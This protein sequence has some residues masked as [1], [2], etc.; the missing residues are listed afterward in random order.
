MLPPAAGPSV[1]LSVLNN[2]RSPPPW[3]SLRRLPLLPPVPGRP[4]VPAS[5][6]LRMAAAI[7][8]FSLG[9]TQSSQL[10]PPRLPLACSRRDCATVCRE[11]NP[12]LLVETQGCNQSYLS[13]P[14]SPI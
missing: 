7:R 3:R 2:Q 11:C 13:I 4:L 5:P 9:T 1:V 14:G 6:L 12:E 10:P 8:A